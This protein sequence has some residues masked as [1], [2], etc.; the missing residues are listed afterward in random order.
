MVLFTV[1]SNFFFHE[2]ILLDLRFF[3]I[4]NKSS[5]FLW[6]M[7]LEITLGSTAGKTGFYMSVHAFS[8][9]TP[10]PR[11]EGSSPSAPAT[12]KSRNSLESRDFLVFGCGGIRSRKPVHF[13]CFALHFRIR[14][15]P[16]L[17]FPSGTSSINHQKSWGLSPVSLALAKN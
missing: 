3:H 17:T 6:C 8:T 16:F 5:K 4:I 10:K 13:A 15:H 11:A 1:P 12:D 14:R 9:S 7:P 2:P